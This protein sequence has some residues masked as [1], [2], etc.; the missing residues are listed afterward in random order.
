MRLPFLVVLDLCGTILSRVHS[1]NLRSKCIKSRYCPDLPDL[2][3]GGKVGSIY[4]RPHL[5]KFLDFLFDNFYVAT[6][7]NTS[8]RS[9]KEIVKAVFGKRRPQLLFSFDKFDLPDKD[10]YFPKKYYDKDLNMLWEMCKACQDLAG[11]STAQEHWSSDSSG[12]GNLLSY[13]YDELE[14]VDS[15][16]LNDPDVKK[17]EVKVVSHTPKII[18]K[19]TWSPSNTIMID[20]SPRKICRSLDN[21]VAVPE[22]VVWS[23]TIDP[24]CDTALLSLKV[25]LEKLYNDDPRDVR[26]WIRNNPLYRYDLSSNTVF[27]TGVPEAFLI[28]PGSVSPP[29]TTRFIPRPDNNASVLEAYRA[30]PLPFS[31]IKWGDNVSE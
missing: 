17:K 15:K 2:C 7:S 11:D 19:M 4:L 21:Y 9:N 14:I 1:P 28:D 22:Y 25:Y 10:T 26:D 6:W 12:A 20:N 8:T 30:D 16:S 13:D 27:D 23:N 29:Q 18:G 31:D 5:A 3:L 24:L